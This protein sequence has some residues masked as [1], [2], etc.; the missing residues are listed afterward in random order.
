MSAASKWTLAEAHF[1][2]HSVD[3]TFGGGQECQEVPFNILNLSSRCVRLERCRLRVSNDGAGPQ[4]QP[5]QSVDQQDDGAA[6]RI[7]GNTSGT[8]I[9]GDDQEAADEKGSCPAA[10]S[11]VSNH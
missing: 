5:F 3:V 2:S 11:Q 10:D 4:E 9:K 7:D 8:E 1:L 6:A